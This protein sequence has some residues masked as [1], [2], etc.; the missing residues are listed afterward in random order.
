MRVLTLLMLLLAIYA[1]VAY[2]EPFDDDEDD[3]TDGELDPDDDTPRQTGDRC[4]RSNACA[5][6]LDCIRSPVL[7]R[8]FPINCGVDAIRTAMDQTGF[9]LASYGRKIM[10]EAGVEKDNL[11]FKRFPDPFNINLFDRD[12][13][14]EDIQ[15]L[16][17][18]IEENE[19]PIDLIL[20]G[21]NNCTGGGETT[22]GEATVAGVTP[23]F[24]ASWELGAGPTYNADIFWGQGTADAV[25]LGILNNCFGIVLGVDA[26]IAGLIGLAFTGTIQDLAVG[27]KQAFPVASFPPFDLQLGVILSESPTFL[28][29][30]TGGASASTG[31]PGYTTCTTTVL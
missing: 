1:T 25:G 30:F 20:Q 21:F 23:Y 16:A 22:D 31:L 6:G 26:G 24:G 17:T 15:A 12:N 29:E 5:Q 8:C 4:G 10:A 19:P 7:R 27:C 28:M 13:R 11:P 14:E 2:E 9:D 18:A 3:N